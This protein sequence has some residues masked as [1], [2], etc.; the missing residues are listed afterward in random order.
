[1]LPPVVVLSC[2]VLAVA[3][4]ISF[5]GVPWGNS[6][7]KI[8]IYQIA[9]S[10]ADMGIK[11]RIFCEPFDNVVFYVNSYSE[12]KKEMENVFVTD[13]RDKSVTNTIIAEKGKIF[14]HSQER[15]IT[16]R[17]QNGAIFVA[18][19]NLQSGRTIKFKTY[20]LNIA[21]KDIMASLASRRKSPKEM[22]AK[23]L[24]EQLKIVP[25]KEERHNKMM[26][27]LL[28]KYTIPLAAFLMGII[29]MPLGTQLKTSVN[30]AACLRR[31]VFGCPFFSCLSP[32]SIFFNAWPVNRPSSCRP[33][34]SNA[35]PLT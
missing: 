22:T 18:E 31:W 12:Q 11:E 20:E 26:I 17:F 1:M 34:F 35:T 25:K 3:A 8:L 16:L 4:V 5:I 14:V 27:E 32:V 6:S 23:E 21:L 33:I 29:G 9:G 30:P 28:E 24:I 10:Q 13:S 7:F 15:I 2:I 19:K